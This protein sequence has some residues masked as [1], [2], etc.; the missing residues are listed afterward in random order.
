MASSALEWV[1]IPRMLAR[2]AT[3]VSY[4]EAMAWLPNRFRY[5]HM[6]AIHVQGAAKRSSPLKFFAVFSATA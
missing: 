6:L 4:M 2:K 5:K 1:L 3:L